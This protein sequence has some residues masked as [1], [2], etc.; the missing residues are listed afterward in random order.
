MCA[1]PKCKCIHNTSRHTIRFVSLYLCVI[2][3][4]NTYKPIQ[5]EKNHIHMHYIVHLPTQPYICIYI[6]NTFTHRWICTYLYFILKMWSIFINLFFHI[7]MF[8]PSPCSCLTF[9]LIY[10]YNCMRIYGCCKF[11]GIGVCACVCF[12]CCHL[13]RD[14]INCLKLL[15]IL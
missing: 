14:D 7:C 5:K 3:N 1:W 6:V 2:V 10:V 4:I 13:Q 11:M 8:C 9:I 15:F 12:Q